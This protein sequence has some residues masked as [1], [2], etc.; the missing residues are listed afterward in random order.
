L[1]NSAAKTMQI[2]IF[3][4]VKRYDLNSKG[5]ALNAS[6]TRARIWKF[7]VM[8]WEKNAYLGN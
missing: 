1:L 4:T 7:V 5:L 6:Q 8:D 3:M 2:A